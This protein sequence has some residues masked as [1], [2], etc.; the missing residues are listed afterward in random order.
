MRAER[1]F[2]RWLDMVAEDALCAPSLEKH[3]FSIPWFKHFDKEA[4]EM[5]A[6]AIRKVVRNYKQLLEGDTDKTQGGRWHGQ[7]NEGQS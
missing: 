7:T 2:C 6:E 1:A 3:C 5:F 4:I